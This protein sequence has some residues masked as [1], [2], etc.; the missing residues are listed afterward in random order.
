MTNDRPTE[1]DNSDIEGEHPGQL[2]PNLI[3]RMKLINCCY[4]FTE[5]SSWSQ[6]KHGRASRNGT[7]EA[8][9]SLAKWSSTT[10]F[11]P[12]NSTPRSSRRCSRAP[13]ETPSP[14]A[15]APCLWASPWSWVR[16]FSKCARAST[17]Y[18]RRTR[19]SGWRKEA[20]SGGSVSGHIFMLWCSW[21][22]A[23]WVNIGWIHCQGRRCVH[24]GDALRG[25]M[26]ERSLG[27]RSGCY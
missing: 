7:G 14:T 6:R 23:P 2:K 21:E 20:M 18:R 8:P 19:G 13:T 26:A 4:S 11:P 9:S 25:D 1:I 5:T 17:T 16:S 22:R 10:R 27:W 12:S 24:G 15:R 3:V